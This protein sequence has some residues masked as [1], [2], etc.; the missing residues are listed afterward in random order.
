MT[1]ANLATNNEYFY[2]EGDL[3]PENNFYLYWGLTDGGY[4]CGYVLFWF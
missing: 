2:K 3:K 1:L 4:R